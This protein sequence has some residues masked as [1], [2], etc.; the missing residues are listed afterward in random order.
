[1]CYRDSVYICDAKFLVIFF[2]AFF[3]RYLLLSTAIAK[4]TPG[5]TFLLFKVIILVCGALFDCSKVKIINDVPFHLCNR[6][7]IVFDFDLQFSSEIMPFDYMRMLTVFM[8]CACDVLSDC[9]SDNG[10]RCCCFFS[11]FRM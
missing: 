8:R 6:P 2:N 3:D 4:C 7:I 5:G 9:A 1:M 10:Q 11:V